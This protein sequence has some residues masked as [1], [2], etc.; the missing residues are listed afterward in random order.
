MNNKWFRLAMVSFVGILIS[1]LGLYVMQFTTGAASH[2]PNQQMQHGGTGQVMAGSPTTSTHS[3]SNQGQGVMQYTSQIPAQYPNPG[4]GYGP[5]YNPG[6][7]YNP[8]S[9][10]PNGYA[11]D[12][13][14]NQYNPMQYQIY[15][16][17]QQINQLREQIN[18]NNAGGMSNNGGGSMSSMPMM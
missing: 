4:M 17:R 2:D 12:L 14:Q 3:G 9:Y 5:N 11:N 18:A 16:M 1:S 7:G 6:M 8:N 15:L 13:F 10:A